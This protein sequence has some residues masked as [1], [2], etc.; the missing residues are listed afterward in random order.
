VAAV[1]GKER[2]RPGAVLQPR[3]PDVQLHPV[4]RLDF[5]D[6]MAGQDIGGGTR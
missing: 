4:D 6:H 3:L 5:E 1:A 2:R